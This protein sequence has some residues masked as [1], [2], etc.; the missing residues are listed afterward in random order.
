[1]NY[2][3]IDPLM[4][5]SGAESEPA[6]SGEPF[7]AAVLELPEEDTLN[8]RGIY[9]DS[10]WP[11]LFERL[12]NWAENNSYLRIPVLKYLFVPGSYLWLYLAL[13]AVLVIMDRR[14]FCLPI[15]I[16]AG[17]YGTML[18]GPTV[19]MRYVYPV[20]LALP[21]LMALATGRRKNG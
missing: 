6:D 5:F 9:K 3:E 12:E 2:S 11:W 18:L 15:A 21:F 4:L 13:A 10:K 14:R 19:Q 7:P 1:M 8:E 17:Y 16:V 20:M